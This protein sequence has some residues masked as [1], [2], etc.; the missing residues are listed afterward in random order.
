MKRILTIVLLGAIFSIVLLNLLT[1][2]DIP[3][4]QTNRAPMGVSPS[5]QE[6]EVPVPAGYDPHFVLRSRPREKINVVETVE[7]GEG[8]YDMLE[9]VS[10][11]L[12]DNGYVKEKVNDDDLHHIVKLAMY[13]SDDFDRIPTS[14]ALSLI[15]NE[16]GF[17]RYDKSNAGA[18]GLCQVI[19][20]YHEDRLMAYLEEGSEYSSD[21]FFDPSLNIKT[22]LDYLSYI[23]GET[24]G[25][26]T[27]ALMWYNQGAKS[28]YNDYVEQ[29]ISSRYSQK[30]IAL[31]EELEDILCNS[32]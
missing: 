2:S 14:I 30:V 18:R 13:I 28:A 25:D 4:Q 32:Q 1:D 15:A 27:F 5:I 23:L 20:K 11:Y 19:P 29:G 9:E 10:T 26:I 24:E 17:D 31:S 12:R 3:D 22:G 7:E 6:D 21:L 8:F 16:S